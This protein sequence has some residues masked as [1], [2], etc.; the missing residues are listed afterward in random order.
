MR[1]RLAGDPVVVAV[2]IVRIGGVRIQDG[3]GVFLY[4]KFSQLRSPACAVP[5]RT[6]SAAMAVRSVAAAR[7]TAL[8]AVR[9][10]ACGVEILSTVERRPGGLGHGGTAVRG[11]E[12]GYLPLPRICGVAATES[13]CR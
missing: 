1:E 13:I 11:V 10:A 5:D 12:L 4:G 3:L 9:S 2:E 7:A 6:R 8:R